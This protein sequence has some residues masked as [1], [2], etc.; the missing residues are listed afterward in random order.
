MPA[1][2][3]DKDKT[4]ASMQPPRRRCCAENKAEFWINH[5]KAQSDSLPHAP[6]YL[7]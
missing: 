7:E 4:L 1:K 2:N 3:V 6:Q 5:D